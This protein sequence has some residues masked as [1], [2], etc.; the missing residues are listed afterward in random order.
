[1]P[2]FGAEDMVGAEGIGW[3]V[4]GIGVWDYKL[5][6]VVGINANGLFK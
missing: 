4:S 2:V 1:M 3:L 5:K 6:F